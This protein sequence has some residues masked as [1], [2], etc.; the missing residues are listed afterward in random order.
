MSQGGVTAA[1]GSMEIDDPPLS[2]FMSEIVVNL[3]TPRKELLET[4]FGPGIEVSQSEGTREWRISEL[5][6]GSP[7]H[8]SGSI[9]LDDVIVAVDDTALHGLPLEVLRQGS[10]CSGPADTFL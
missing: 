7:A 6:E 9:A 5:F 3:P 8:L 10:L 4:V 2:S 1:I